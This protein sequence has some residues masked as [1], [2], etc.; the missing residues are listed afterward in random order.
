ME[1][2]P[3]KTLTWWQYRARFVTDD[4]VNTGRRFLKEHKNLLDQIGREYGVPRED[5]VAILGIETNYGQST[6]PYR[7]I[8]TLMTLAFDYPA[9]SAFFRTELRSF[10]LLAHDGD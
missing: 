2:P 5:L 9:R 1:Q 7:E 4:R 3:E 10:L 6:G 8:D